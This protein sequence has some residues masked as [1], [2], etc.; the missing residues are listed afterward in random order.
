M[1]NYGEFNSDE[2]LNLKSIQ[3]L[4]YVDSTW[5][6]IDKEKAEIFFFHGNNKYSQTMLK[7]HILPLNHFSKRQKPKIVSCTR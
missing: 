4:K 2:C 1:N 3:T 7:M 5:C 6:K